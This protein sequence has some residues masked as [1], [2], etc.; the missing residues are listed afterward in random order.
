MRKRRTSFDMI[1][2]ILQIALTP[3]QRT[4]LYYEGKLGGTQYSRNLKLVLEQGLLEILP[5]GLVQTSG[6]GRRYL[7][8]FKQIKALIGVEDKNEN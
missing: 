8:L 7:E 1:Y 6:K 3:K 5:G 2:D 4:D